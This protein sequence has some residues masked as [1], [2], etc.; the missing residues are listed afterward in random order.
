MIVL[1]I[2]KLL[3]ALAAAF[4]VGGWFFIRN[5]VLHDGDFLGMRTIQESAEEHAQED[6]KPS[7]K[8]LQARDSPLLTLL[9]MFIR[10]IRRT[11]FFP[12][13]AALSALFPI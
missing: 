4:L 7:L 9:S 2:L 3:V 10:D 1:D 13:C 5:A 6:F 12:L 11:G 8:R